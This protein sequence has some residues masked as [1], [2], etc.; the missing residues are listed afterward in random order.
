[1]T[2]RISGAGL[3][4]LAA[5]LLTPF[6]VL[7]QWS[8][9]PALNLAVAD[10]SGEQVQAKIKPT[11]DGGAYVSWFD[12]STGGY[13]VYLQRL[14][15]TG[16]E[17]WASNGVLVADRS[18]GSTQDYGLDIDATGNALLTFRDD[19]FTGT[20]ITAA[21][22]SP[23]GVLLWGSDGVQ[24]SDGMGFVAAPKIAGTSD[25]N[26]V[27]AW[28][29]DADVTVQKLNGSGVAQW[30]TGI[31]LTDP[32][33][34]SFSAS[35]MH[36][37]DDGSVILSMVQQFGF[38]SPKHLYAQKLSNTGSALWGTNPLAILDNG[39][40]QFGNFPKFV[41]DGSGGA[42]FAWYD[43]S[44]LALQ[45]FAQRVLSDG[46]EA[47]AHNGVATSTAPQDRTAPAVAFNPATNE[48]LVVWREEGAATFGVYAQKFDASGVRQ[49]T[50]AGAVIAALDSTELGNVNGLAADGGLFASWTRSLSFSDQRIVAAQLNG[51][52]TTVWN[53]AIADVASAASGK[54]RLVA[55]LSTD[56]VAL[57]AW[58]DA[59]DDAGD[60]YMQNVNF[61]GTLGA[62]D[63]DGDGVSDDADNCTLAAN[64]DQR[65]TNA[66]GFGNVCDADFNG[67]CTIDFLDLG[68]LKSV[69][70]GNDPD[71]DLNGDGTVDFLD[72]GALKSAFFGMPGPSGVPNAC[73]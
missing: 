16:T 31:V 46:S 38:S 26:V 66:D 5:L 55:E 17:Q 41:P 53:P 22:I 71:A 69:F 40:L 13:D 23:A 56:G 29:S 57:L 36:D 52:G 9:N 58:T 60:I 65:D 10:R 12:N 27:V 25:G 11:A 1:M 32:L 43:T 54:T 48:T 73:Q 4:S 68:T 7:A 6:T 45:C 39:S 21:R 34:G 30:G 15:S 14:D 72:L 49:W 63:T 20:R 64:A 44:G 2:A 37:S 70:F 24:L 18:F 33:G 61:D 67:D 51:S 62:P 19:R 50:D 47:F 28:T 59:R 8:S 3:A 42:A 35:D